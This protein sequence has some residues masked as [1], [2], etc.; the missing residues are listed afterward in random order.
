MERPNRLFI[1]LALRDIIENDDRNYQEELI[2]ALGGT[3]YTGVWTRY[4][5]SPL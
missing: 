5:C 2:K 3:I 4:Q 1:S